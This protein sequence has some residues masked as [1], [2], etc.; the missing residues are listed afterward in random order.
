MP[1]RDNVL[2][3][4]RDGVDAVVAVAER[5]EDWEARACGA[6]TAS[7][8]AR[9]LAA[10]AAWY[11]DWLR[12]AIAGVIERPFQAGVIDERNEAEIAARSHLDGPAAV[13]EFAATARS[14][15]RAAAPE[16]ERTFAYPYGVTTVGG[17]LGLAASEWHL[18]AWDMSCATP[19]RYRPVDAS[20]LFR[21][22]A[23]SHADRV[24]GVK[25]RLLGLLIPLG[26]RLRP[27][28]TL[29]DHSGRDRRR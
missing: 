28:E 29:L 23:T 17:H 20:R 6:W 7:D 10:V 27:W 19:T 11:H 8:T 15:V 26:A 4:Y 22:A 16:W 21:V 14:Y 12:R 9:H 24:G 18:H 3:A 2:A 13:T 1:G 25:G 5:I